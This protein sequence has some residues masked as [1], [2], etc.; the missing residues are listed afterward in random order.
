MAVH[1]QALCLLT[2][3][4]VA[5]ATPGWWPSPLP[6]PGPGVPCDQECP[7]DTGGAH[8]T[9]SALVTGGCTQVT[10]RRNSLKV[11]VGP[12]LFWAHLTWK[13]NGPLTATSSPIAEFLLFP[14]SSLC[15]ASCTAGGITA[16]TCQHF[17]NQEFAGSK[18][19]WRRPKFTTGPTAAF[20]AHLGKPAHLPSVIH[21]RLPSQSERRGRVHTPLLRTNSRDKVWV[22]MRQ[23]RG[24]RGQMDSSV[25]AS[26]T[27]DQSPVSGL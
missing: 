13:S 8:V 23:P 6:S 25:S 18:N 2:A 19:A 14:G 22:E 9:R 20:R 24:R 4:G 16:P 3:L 26:F 11:E 5:G 21:T 15:P 12:G 7:R 27:N 10:R 17:E 1:G